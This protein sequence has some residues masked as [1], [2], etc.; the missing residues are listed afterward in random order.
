MKV[1]PYLS[2]SSRCRLQEINQTGVNL[3]QSILYERE[4]SSFSVFVCSA[5]EIVCMVFLGNVTTR[6]DFEF[7]VF[8]FGPLMCVYTKWKQVVD[9]F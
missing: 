2:V 9:E 1:D 5:A 6:A 8:D 7:R 3:C 4:E